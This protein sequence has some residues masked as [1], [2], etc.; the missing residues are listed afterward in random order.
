MK[1]YQVTDPEFKKY[2]RVITG[3]DLAELLREMK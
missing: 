3:Y 1:Q 2:G